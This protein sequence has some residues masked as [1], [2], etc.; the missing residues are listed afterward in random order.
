MRVSPSARIYSRALND[1]DSA[2]A[3][4]FPDGVLDL[5][6]TLRAQILFEAFPVKNRET[7][8]EMALDPVFD[9]FD[10]AS[11]HHARIHR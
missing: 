2:V 7:A 8:P 6:L 4:R 9:P 5:L 1:F 10:L 11:A 3:A